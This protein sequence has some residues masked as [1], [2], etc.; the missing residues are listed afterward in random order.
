MKK[1]VLILLTA[2]ALM[3]YTKDWQTYTDPQKVFSVQFPNTPKTIVQDIPTKAGIIKAQQASY[4]AASE[5][6]S[7]KKYLVSIASL[8][9]ERVKTTEASYAMLSK[10]VEGSVRNHK[11][12]LVSSA[13]TTFEGHLAIDAEMTMK[14]GSI[15]IKSRTLL[16]NDNHIGLIVYTPVKNKDN[17]DVKRFFSSFKLLKK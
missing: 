4:S 1:V 2:L 8:P 12:V 9:A 14:D 7:N 13:K 11:A 15:I 5:T 6:E 3:A 10:S 17:A 16:I